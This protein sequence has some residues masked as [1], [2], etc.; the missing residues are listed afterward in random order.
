MKMAD[1]PRLPTPPCTTVVPANEYYAN[2]NYVSRNRTIGSVSFFL[3]RVT[4]TGQPD[5]RLFVD[6]VLCKKRRRRGFLWEYGSRTSR[7]G[8]R[9]RREKFRS[10]DV[11]VC[12]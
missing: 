12:Q 5:V 2:A 11:S 4:K 7:T 1:T 10:D 3:C 9:R 6:R 8:G